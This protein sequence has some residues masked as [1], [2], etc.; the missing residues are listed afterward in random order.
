MKH[1]MKDL[2]WRKQ[3]QQVY[4]VYVHQ[5]VWLVGRGSPPTP[6][7]QRTL[8]EMKPRDA[9]WGRRGT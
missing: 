7:S 6:G 4:I 3:S 9:V 5:Y 2:C 8:V 1:I